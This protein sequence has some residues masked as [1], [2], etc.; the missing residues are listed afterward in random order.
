MNCDTRVGLSRMVEAHK[1]F[2]KLPSFSGKGESWHM[3][4]R[5]LYAVLDSANL[6]KGLSEE[7]PDSA[8]E[9]ADEQ[10]VAAAKKAQDE[11]DKRNREIYNVLSYYTESLAASTVM[12]YE[13][14]RNGKEAWL[15]LLNKFEHVGTIGK[16]TLQ[17]EMIQCRM[18]DGEDPDEYFQRV[19]SIQAR[20]VELGEVA[21][22]DSLMLG[23]VLKNLP[24]EYKSLIDILDTQDGLTYAIFKER[25]STYHRR[26]LGHSKG[27]SV[28]GK[29]KDEGASK[30]LYT[31]D[32][33]PR[34]SCFKCGKHGHFFKDCPKRKGGSETSKESKSGRNDKKKVQE[35]THEK[36]VAFATGVVLATDIAISGSA[37]TWVVDS[38]CTR[39]MSSR[40]ECISNITF[41]DG[42]VIVAGGRK[43]Q[44][45]GYGN[46]H[47]NA[48]SLNNEVVKLVIEDVLIVPGLG[49]NLLSVERIMQKGG[50]VCFEQGC[51]RIKIKGH[52]FLVRVNEGLYTWSHY[53]I[54][55]SSS[56]ETAKAFM[57]AS[58]KSSLWHK[59]LGHRN[60]DS[61]KELQSKDVGIPMDFQ[62]I[63]R[64]EVCETAKHTMISFPKGIDRK[65]R[66]P[67][68]Q[69]HMDLV[70]PVEVSS[71]GGARYAV[72][73]VDEFTRWINIYC[74][75]SKD[76]AIE[77]SKQYVLDVKGLGNSYQLKGLRSDNAGELSSD[78]FKNW[79]KE[80]GVI[81]S[82]GGPYS[83]QQ[84]GI[85]ERA[86]RT[87]FEMVRCLLKEAKLGKR[88]WAEAA[89]TAVYTINRLPSTGIEGDTPYF[90]VYGKNCKVS[91][92]RVFGCTA[93]V[94]KYDH[95]RQKL[96]DK[97]WKGLLVGYDEHNWRCY[98]ILDPGKGLVYRTVHVTFNEEEFTGGTRAQS[99]ISNTDDEGDEDLVIPSHEEQPEDE[100]A[101]VEPNQNVM[102]EETTEGVEREGV[103]RDLEEE[104]QAR[105]G[106][107]HREFKWCRREE[108][109][110]QGIHRAH[111]TTEFAFVA[112]E[113]LSMFDDP[114]TY[115][116]ALKS[117]ESEEWIEAM[118]QEYEAL[119]K[120]KTWEL[121]EKPAGVNIVGS[122]WL[123]KTKRDN[124]GTIVRY[125]ARLVAQGFSQ[126]YGKD[127]LDTFSPVA[128]FTSIRVVLFIANT[129][130]WDIINMDVQ[131]AFLNSPVEEEIYLKQ[132][133]GYIKN[134][135]DG[136]PLVCRMLKSLYGLKQASRNWN[137][138]IDKWLKGY[139]FRPCEADRCLYMYDIDNCIMLLVLWVDDLIIT[140]N[141][142]ACI[143]EFRKKISDGFDMKDL[144]E[145][146]WILG[147]EIIR[148][149]SQ[150]TLEMNQTGYI[151]LVLKRFG[152]D[153]CK[154]IGTPAEGYLARAEGQANK[155]YMS[156]V[157][158]LLY[159]AMI[160]RPDI[161][162]AVQA[163]GRHL[164][165]TGEE[166]FA[167]AKRVMRY[168]QGSKQLGIKYH[169]GEVKLVGYADA[170]WASDKD[171]RRS[172][173]GYLFKLGSSTIS[174]GCRLQPTV[175][176]S[177]SEAEYMSASAAVQEAMYLR[178][179][180]K[181]L[182]YNQES[183]TIIW[184]DNRG[185]ID[186]SENP[187]HHKRSKHIDIR[188]HY[189]REHVVANDI[190]L[191]YINSQEQLA[192]LLTKPLPR[193]RTLELRGPV[194]GYN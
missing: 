65:A 138:V 71:I 34:G 173:T 157:G 41:A 68:E 170:D 52:E 44:S 47:V 112:A 188:Y 166:H 133:Q 148:D 95:Q 110:I 120:A 63:E 50:Q 79:C 8:P 167:A 69:V 62:E 15:K 122:R 183:A 2:T 101:A 175:A 139:G 153:E 137:L 129:N 154:S 85:V 107:H 10:V 149:R 59:R 6:L 49:P 155:E 143:Q 141:D 40:V 128:R 82:F 100:A 35:T 94:H 23:I 54:Q 180:L 24:A 185:C 26:H 111:F 18:K 89:A 109:N 102:R 132:P 151:N 28:D 46:M 114:V 189:I 125:K 22:P 121:V 48:K 178:Q 165:A 161:S 192:D 97:A 174:W 72:V 176:L 61:I 36:S 84:M 98:R 186:L 56:D 29:S 99:D 116:Q 130:D 126:Q 93:Y 20:L 4:K 16:A 103:Y 184:E 74:V 92:M 57:T 158:S 3:W 193:Q 60:V 87:I 31:K 127:Y 147:M 146:K 194:L 91:H 168:L 162:Y 9:G 21:M 7:R 106:E 53:P 171:T 11:W 32:K 43:L 150:R 142:R 135:A 17:S 159:A 160:T 119:I 145:L 51:N 38:G 115:Q 136:K 88:Y 78:E 177:T 187:V 96:D 58:D 117:A 81:Q 172:T 123:Y 124:H 67:F 13:S 144:G 14:S 5:K 190:K 134:G 182:K 80:Q 113:E 55:R 1:L 131:T 77:A 25:I 163:L 83:P 164:Q 19:E 70:G 76:E 118:N 86:N 75:K 73:F 105:P 104:K 191:T 181:D 66:I 169:Q 37:N 12:Q 42:E 179:L 45:I 27:K 39:H 156:M 90:R 108:C 64:C 152:M 33:K 30:A 140:G